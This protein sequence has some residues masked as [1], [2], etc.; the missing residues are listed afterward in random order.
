MEGSGGSWGGKE[1]GKEGR[2]KGRKQ[3]EGIEGRGRV[4]RR[5][6][7]VTTDRIGEG[8]KGEGEVEGAASWEQRGGLRE[9]ESCVGEGR[10]IKRQGDLTLTDKNS[11]PTICLDLAMLA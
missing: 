4:K 8:G 10:G 2:G 9:G 11:P 6:Q 7:V 5:E 3:G 1:E